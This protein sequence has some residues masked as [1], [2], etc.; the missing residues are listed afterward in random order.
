MNILRHLFHRTPQTLS[1]VN[2][3]ELWAKSYPAEAHNILMK[4]EQDNMLTLMPSLE[5][6]VVLDLACGTGRYGKIAQNQNARQVIGVDNSFAMLERRAIPQ[7]IQATSEE[8]PLPDESIDIVLCGLAL[9]HLP[10]IRPSLSEISRVLRPN[11]IALISDFHPYQ[12]LSGARRTFQ[13]DNKNYAV[14][15][16]V[17]H[18]SDY[19]SDGQSV[20]LHITDL[21]EPLFKE[22]SPVVLVVRYEKDARD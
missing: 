18:I 9:G 14:E 16:Y 19:F 22:N 6:K 2:A 7:G 15:H 1:S 4:I 5:D 8:T 12:F 21:R 13:A 10:E 3:Y 11:G 17:H 20:N